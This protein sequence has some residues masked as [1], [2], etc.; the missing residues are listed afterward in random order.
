M[1]LDC[2]YMSQDDDVLASRLQ[3]ENAEMII[4]IGAELGIEIDRAKLEKYR[5]RDR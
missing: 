3:I 5:L 2:T 1:I 4:P